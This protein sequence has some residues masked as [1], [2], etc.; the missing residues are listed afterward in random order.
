MTV[1]FVIATIITF[2]GIDWINRRVKAK[3]HVPV[4]AMPAAAQYPVRLPDGIFFTKSHTWL[5]L[6][7]SGKVRLGV[8][9]FVGRMIENP[10]VVLL[11]RSGDQVSR[12]EPILALK[13]RGHLLTLRAPIDGD[14]VDINEELQKRPEL[15]KEML[16]SDGW[17]YTIKPSK[18]AE[19]KGLL[20][21]TE[22]QQWMRDE[23]AR[24]R[25]FFAGATATAQLSPAYLQD[26]GAPVAG[27]MND[28]N[29]NVWRNFEEEFLTIE[30]TERK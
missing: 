25:D 12:G 27:I 13:D 3:K 17:A 30:S 28:M 16:F 4:T 26:G 9:D 29:E 19:L 18:F 20:L 15:M 2:L 7:P 22:T 8:D 5:N 24:L 23:F 11:K 6:F 1:L 10:E 21:G 14:V